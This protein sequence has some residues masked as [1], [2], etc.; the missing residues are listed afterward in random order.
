LETRDD[1]RASGRISVMTVTIRAAKAGD[2]GEILRL[3]QALA[4]YENASDAVKATVQSLRAI[5]FGDNPRAFAH[6]AEL[7]G[8]VVGMTVWFFN[9]STWTGR[10][11]I[12]LEDLFVDPDVRGQGVARL[13]FR[14][15]ATEAKAHDCAR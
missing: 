10:H 14:A 12:Y 9:F 8:Q 15:L 4:D 5:L 6:I 13:L 2:E 3:V 11:G 7:N 1:T